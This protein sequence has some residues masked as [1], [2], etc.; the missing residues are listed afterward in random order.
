MQAP[1]YG[2]QKLVQAHSF[3]PHQAAGHRGEGQIG[4]RV[5]EEAREV[6]VTQKDCHGC[7]R[8]RSP[9]LAS[10]M[11]RAEIIVAKILAKITAT[12]TMGECG[13]CYFA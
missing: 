1:S 13:A 6:P 5:V 2:P 10:R 4:R 7:F 8:P 11:A 3:R 9:P 12:S